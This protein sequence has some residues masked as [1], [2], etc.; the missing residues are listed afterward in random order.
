MYVHP[1]FYDVP[2]R[3]DNFL[4][5]NTFVD[6]SLAFIPSTIFWSLQITKTQKIQ[7]SIVFALNILYVLSVNS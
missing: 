1:C 4:A 7:L 2:Q 6:A 3:T 5:Y